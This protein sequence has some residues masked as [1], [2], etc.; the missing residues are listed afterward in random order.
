M[1]KSLF[2]RCAHNKTN[3]VES[4]DYYKCE[5]G[6]RSKLLEEVVEHVS[7]LFQTG[8]NLRL[9][10]GKTVHAKGGRNQGSGK[11]SDGLRRAG[12]IV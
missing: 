1:L 6:R 5:G 3:Y 11:E 7:E 4:Y 2:G 9:F 10:L 12:L 8:R